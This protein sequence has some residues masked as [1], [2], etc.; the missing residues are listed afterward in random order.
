MPL[1]RMLNTH[2]VQYPEGS[3]RNRCPSEDSQ[4][5][6]RCIQKGV[7]KIDTPRRIVR[8]PRGAISR[9]E[10]SKQMPFRVL[11]QRPEGSH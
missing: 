10:S 8:H 2:E 9:R 6:T 5:P 1:E 3:H 11:L 4:T 7:I